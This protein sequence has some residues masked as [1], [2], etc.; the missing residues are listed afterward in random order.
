MLAVPAVPGGVVHVIDVADTTTTFVHAALPT[1]TAEVPVNKVPVI[2]IAVPPA[3]EPDVGLT[4]VTVGA[5]VLMRTLLATGEKLESINQPAMTVNPSL[6][7]MASR[8]AS[9]CAPTPKFASGICVHVAPS[10]DVKTSPIVTKANSEPMVTSF[11]GKT[12][13]WKTPA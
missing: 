10:D 9:S 7:S 8:K 2:V 13:V 4:E 3:V 11:R 5:A 6:W 12:G 1:V